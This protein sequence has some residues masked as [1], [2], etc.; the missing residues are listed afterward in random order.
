MKK[1]TQTI[2]TL[3]FLIAGFSCSKKDG[4][5]TNQPVYQDVAYQQDFSKK[6]NLEQEG[7]TLKNVFSDRNGAIQLYSSAGLLKPFAGEFLYPGTLVSDKTYRPIADK[8]ILNL[9]LYKDQFVYLD[10]KAVLSNSWAGSLYSRYSMP[11]ATMFEGG[12]DFS[13]LISD[14]ESLQYLKDSNAIWKGKNNEPIADILF[15][16]SRNAF[17]ILGKKSISLF[18]VAS[19]NL[20][21]VFSGNDLTCFSLFSNASELVVGTSDGYFILDANTKQQKGETVK[22]LP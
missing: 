21:L 4:G 11:N 9:T 19:K 16:D 5:Q 3:C 22:K 18:D 6:F 8:K 20:S 10:D 7:V 17:W 15:D 13:F 12:K 1:A 14:G 2:C